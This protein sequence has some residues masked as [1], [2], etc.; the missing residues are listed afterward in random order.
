MAAAFFAFPAE[1]LANCGVTDTGI[2][3]D[4][5]FKL[6]PGGL[7]QA[8]ARSGIGVGGYYYAELRTEG[9]FSQL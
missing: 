8:L 7:R 1:A 9:R 3:E 5:A 4:A 6:D 2:P